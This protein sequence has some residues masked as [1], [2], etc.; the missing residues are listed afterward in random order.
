MYVIHLLISLFELIAKRLYDGNLEELCVQASNITLQ[1]KCVSCQPL[2][3]Q[4]TVHISSL[5]QEILIYIFRWVVSSDLDMR[6]L[7]VLSMVR[8]ADLEKNVLNLSLAV[9]VNAC[10]HQKLLLQCL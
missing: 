9:N 1:Q 4:K 10:M 5:P 7:E 6:S 3:S 2:W 8:G